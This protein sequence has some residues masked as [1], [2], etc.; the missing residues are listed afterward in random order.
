MKGAVTDIKQNNRKRE[1]FFRKEGNTFS[2]FP[3]LYYINV[4]YMHFGRHLAKII[5]N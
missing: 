3:F 2:I 4:L 5:S 1:E